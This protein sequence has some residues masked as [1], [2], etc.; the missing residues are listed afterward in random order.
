[1][2]LTEITGMFH[3]D[4]RKKANEILVDRLPA[5]D[6]P[7]RFEYKVVRKNGDTNWISLYADTV[8]VGGRRE[9]LAGCRDITSRKLAEKQLKD[10]SQRLEEM[11]ETRS[12]ELEKAQQELL[13]KERLAV[14][15]HFAGSIS[16]EL[17][18]PLAAI[19]SSAYFLKM[20][21]GTQNNDNDIDIDRHIGSISSNVAKSTAIIQSLL[22]LSRM[23]KPRTRE[24]D[25]AQLVSDMLRSCKIPPRVQVVLDFP[26]RQCPVAVEA[27]QIR[28]ALKN[29]VQNALQAMPE[30]GTLS[31]A[32]GPLSERNSLSDRKPPNES[33]QPQG[34]HSTEKE[35]GMVE[36]R[37]S[38]SGPGI[39][40][41]NIE[42][43]FEPLFT[44]KTHGIGFGL[45]IARMI[46]EN[47]GGTIR[48]ESEAG[49]GTTM[50]VALPG[51]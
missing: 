16:H 39:S 37:F 49:A 28:I 32:I 26:R 20:K 23:E 5:G 12:R 50:S 3:P 27:E 18:N 21:L 10:Y 4:H 14:L 47:H 45:S 19:D 34:T 35:N 46:V 9:I 38:D 31:I 2:S 11:V 1:M 6:R 44:T 22:N 29:I 13:A 25:L 40:S 33:R 17:R 51:A 8:N 48:A 42:K 7:N 30:S 36:I 43:I 41:E 15:G 24:T